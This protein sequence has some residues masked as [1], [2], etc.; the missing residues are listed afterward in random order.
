MSGIHWPVPL[1]VHQFENAAQINPTLARVFAAMRATDLAQQSQRG[2]ASDVFYASHDQLLKRVQLPEFQSL[3]S[4]IADS[5]QKTISQAN[6]GV[7]PSGRMR[8]QL[9]MVGCWFQ[10]QNGMAF[11]DVHTHGNCSWSGVYYVQCDELAK[12]QTHPTLGAMNGVT[13][14]YGPYTNW[15]SGAHM[16]IG[17]A[18]LQKNT[19]DIEPEPG[20]LVV[21]P[22][23]LPHKA[24][25]YEGEQDRIIVSFNAQVHS[26]DGDQVFGYDAT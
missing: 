18:Y 5:L 1:G 19:L 21:F 2:K 17:N 14:F 25:P 12:R 13:R 4:F 8:L 10:I 23:Y 15:L 7:W 11:H 9:Q 6:S 26:P 24:M 16:D 3:I 20:K 22:S